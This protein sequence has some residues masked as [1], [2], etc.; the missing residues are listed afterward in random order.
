M[1]LFAHDVTY[2]VRMRILL[3]PSVACVYEKRSPMEKPP[4]KEGASKDVEMEGEEAGND[5]TEGGGG[6]AKSE[7]QAQKDRDLLT[8]EG[9]HQQD[10]PQCDDSCLPPDIR[11]QM[12]LIERGVHQKEVRYINR[13][14]RSLRSLRRKTNDA[15][16]RRVTV[17]YYPA[18]ESRERRRRGNSL[19]FPFI[20]LASERAAA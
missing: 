5:K 20:S 11:E 3:T 19:T 18:G 9:E 4:E 8:F 13:A 6:E 1:R 14:L 15:I 17:A 7:Q 10:W 16:L 2:I 12:K